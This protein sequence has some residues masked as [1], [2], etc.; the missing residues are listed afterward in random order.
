MIIPTEAVCTKCHNDESP[1]WDPQKYTL[2]DGSKAGFDFE[3][4]VKVIAHPVPEG[5]DPTTA[6]E[7]A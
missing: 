6:G 1:A 4:A 7:A 2:A 3:Q 5:Y